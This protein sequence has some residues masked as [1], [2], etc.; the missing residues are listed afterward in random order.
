M[1]ALK[2]SYFHLPEFVNGA[3]TIADTKQSC[4]IKRF[5]N[6]VAAAGNRRDT[7]RA[8]GKKRPDSIHVDKVGQEDSAI[9][10]PCLAAATAVSSYRHTVAPS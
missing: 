1:K 8:D 3:L 9:R 5:A 2:V 10:H 4:I 6:G 7:A